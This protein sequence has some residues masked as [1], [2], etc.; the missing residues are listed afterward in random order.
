MH[1][2]R[3]DPEANLFR[4]YRIEI[5]RG[6]FGDWGLVRNWGRV[7]TAGQLRTDWFGTEAEAKDARF[8][9]QM[10]KAK[11]GYL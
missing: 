6:L 2:T 10:Q 4:F 5:V 7:G 3:T 1:L 11:R 9:L 8:T